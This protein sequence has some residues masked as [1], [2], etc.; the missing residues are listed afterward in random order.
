MKTPWVPRL[1]RGRV[2]SGRGGESKSTHNC[3]ETP[4]K[5]LI[6][7]AVVVDETSI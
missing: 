4:I 5:T 1:G 7:P 3:N 2:P 6:D